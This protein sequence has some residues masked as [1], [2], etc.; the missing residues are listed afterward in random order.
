MTPGGEE[1]KVTRVT[2]EELER[3][4]AN[5]MGENI[6]RGGPAFLARHALRLWD[7]RD[8]WEKYGREAR[9]WLEDEHAWALDDKGHS[10]RCPVCAFLSQ[11]PPLTSTPSPET[12]EGK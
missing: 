9:E 4:A 10:V 11:P 8:A 6:I 12:K 5:G 7:E 2:R 1:C 3:Y